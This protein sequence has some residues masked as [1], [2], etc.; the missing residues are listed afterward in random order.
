MSGYRL[1]TYP[2]QVLVLGAGK[3]VTKSFS[4]FPHSLFP[5]LQ[6]IT[7]SSA[8]SAWLIPGSFSAATL[9]KWVIFPSHFASN[10]HNYNRSAPVFP[11][12][13]PG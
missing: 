3:K 6:C 5:G 9:G 10:L 7:S 13:S 11:F 12:H 1:S 8:S 2:A 4:G